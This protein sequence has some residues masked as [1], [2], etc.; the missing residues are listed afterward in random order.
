M[1]QDNNFSPGLDLSEVVGDLFAGEADALE[2]SAIQELSSLTKT[3]ELG[4]LVGSGGLKEVF[5]CQD[6]RTQR[7][8]A[9]ATVKQGL[10]AFYDAVL[11]HEARLTARLSHPNIIKIYD[12][13]LDEQGRPYFTMDL[14]SNVNLL[15][16]SRDASTFRKLE[17]FGVVCQAISYAHSQ[18]IIHLDLKP[19]NIQCDRFGEVLVCDWGLACLLY[20]SPSP[21]DA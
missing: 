6:M 15:E 16:Y 8:V 1:T 18:R 4:E 20:T 5:V 17:V 21:R 7:D 3:Y 11:V 10:G 9:Y 2:H 14:K 19:D 12:L 13:G